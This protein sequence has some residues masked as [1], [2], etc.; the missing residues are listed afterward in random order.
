MTFLYP[1]ST[2]TNQPRTWLAQMA[3]NKPDFLTP[4]GH[5]VPRA[6]GEAALR[7]RQAVLVGDL[8]VL[9]PDSGMTNKFAI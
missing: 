4:D 1:L 2:S 3:G 6:A 5:I 7:T 9:A 8:L